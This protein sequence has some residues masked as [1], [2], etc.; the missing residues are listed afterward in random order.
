MKRRHGYARWALFAVPLFATSFALASLAVKPIGTYPV[1]DFSDKNCES[2]PR[3]VICK[4]NH[5]AGGPIGCFNTTCEAA[6]AGAYQC[7]KLLG[8]CEPL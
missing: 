6:A 2:N 7:K 4:R 5:N 1:A 8:A 3:P